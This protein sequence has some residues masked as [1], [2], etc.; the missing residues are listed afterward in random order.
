MLVARGILG[1]VRGLQVNLEDPYGYYAEAVTEERLVGLVEKL[2]ANL[3]IVFARDA[4]G[5]ALYESRLYPRHPRARI[6]WGRLREELSR[7]GATLVVMACHTSS[8]VLAERHPDWVQ[9]GPDGEPRTL[10]HHPRG[11]A[12]DPEWPLICPNSPAG[13]LFIQEAGEVLDA[14]GADA[15]LLDSLRYMPD[16]GRACYCRW[17]REAFRRETGY[18]LHTGPHRGREAEYRAAWEWRYRVVRRLVEGIAEAAHARGAALLYNNHPGGWSGRGLRFVEEL[19]DLIDG[20]FV[21][22]SEE[23]YRGPFWRSFIVKASIAVSWPKPVW[24]TRNAFPLLRPVTSAPPTLIEHGVLSL[25]AAGASPVVT[26]FSSA[27]AL[28]TRFEDAVARVYEYLES[29]EDILSAR[30]PQADVAILYSSLSHDWHVHEKPEV[31]IGELMG[32]SKSLSMLHYAWGVVSARRLEALGDMGASTLIAADTGIV[33][34]KLEER[35]EELVESGVRVIVT[36]FAG[37]RRPDGTETWRLLLQE[38]LGIRFEGVEELGVY[39]VEVPDSLPRYVP[40][41]ASDELFESRRWDPF[42]G[43]VARVN[44]DYAHVLGYIR[45]PR[46]PMGYE[47]TLGRSTPPPGERLW[48]GIVASRDHRLAYHAYRLG[49]HAHILGLPEYVELLRLS[50]DAVKAKRRFW[51]EDAPDLVELH[52]YRVGEGYAIHLLNNCWHI[53]PHAVEEATTPGRAPGFEP[54]RGLTVP[55]RAPGCG[56]VRLVV[57]LEDDAE[58][59][60]R[61]YPYPGEA[62]EVTLSAAEKASIDVDLNGLH[63]LVYILP[64]G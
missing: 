14:T 37:L 4:W 7:R 28:D 26:V 62:N 2:R 21:E 46:A 30:V 19:Y 51:L 40:M 23:D 25:V 41:G 10:D 24:S 35:L 22:A 55:R 11:V 59:V 13:R 5:R 8:K 20:V 57:R 33:D 39:H 1:F 60:A 18:E 6:D 47:Y 44:V 42:L 64:R 45:G 63:V 15:L 36:G 17:C 56:R 61:V 27:L 32:I 3:L 31:Y 49:L 34:E 54:L 29:L 58:Y 9:R 43:S 52:A 38:R 50:L 53:I 48:P 12:V 16:T